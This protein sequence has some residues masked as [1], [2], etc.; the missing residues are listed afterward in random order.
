M[1]TNTITIEIDSAVSDVFRFTVDPHNTHLWIDSV[2]EERIN[3]DDVGLG[4]E[5]Y[6]T[7]KAMDGSVGKTKAVITGFEMH[8]FIEF[9]FTG[10]AYKCSY[11]YKPQANKTI[12]IYSEE[13]TDDSALENPMDKHC[14]ER[15]KSLLESHALGRSELPTKMRAVIRGEVGLEISEV[16]LPI[17]QSDEVLIKV[18][19]SAI[20]GSDLPIYNWDDPWTRE[21]V[22]PGQIIGHEFCGEVIEVGSNVEK[23]SCGDFVTA[24]GHIFCGE[25]FQCRTGLA[26]ICSNIKLVGFDF[27]GSFAEYICIPARNIIKLPNLPKLVAAIQDP[28]GNAVHAISKVNITGRTVLVTGCGPIGLICISLAKLAGANKIY[29]TD[30]SD[31]RL[32]RALKVG[33]TLAFNPNKCSVCEK[34]LDETAMTRGVDVSFEM[35]GA[36]SAIQLCF[37][38]VRPG[39]EVVLLGLPKKPMLFDFSNSLIAKGILIHGVIGR[40][41][42]QT[43]FQ[44]QQLQGSQ[45]LLDDL[46]SMVTHAYPLEEYFRG[47]EL[48][49]KGECGKVVLLP[50][51]L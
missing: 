47:F 17:P 35:S 16:P 40:E 7:T 39:G 33:A 10:I 45:A 27:P 12:L 26:H 50:G 20:C 36:P 41:V 38:A 49:N 24:E 46:A 2:I 43:W 28:L 25:C 18:L 11:T 14:F 21:V 37:D 29:A 30:I 32:A 22:K 6:Q 1:K 9:S 8:K 3:T 19:A 23:I 51:Q 13:A 48:M 15:L 34:I 42:F 4:T 44:S 5:Y 31:Y